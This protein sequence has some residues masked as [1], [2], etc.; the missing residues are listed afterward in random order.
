MELAR[1]L[2]VFPTQY[3][4]KDHEFQGPIG[5]ALAWM[6]SRG[7]SKIPSEDGVPIEEGNEI[8][9]PDTNLVDPPIRRHG[10]G[11]QAGRNRR[12]CERRIQRTLFD[13]IVSTSCSQ[14]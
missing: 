14:L 4:L 6:H 3:G 9:S 8:T 5:G 1:S 7:D 13:R 12:W 10:F 2:L 11:G